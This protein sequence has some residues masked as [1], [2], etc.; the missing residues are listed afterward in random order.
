MVTLSDE[1]HEPGRCPGLS[2][3]NAWH[4]HG[5]DP[6]WQYVDPDGYDISDQMYAYGAVER[7]RWS[8]PDGPDLIEYR[9][10]DRWEEA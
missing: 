10:G 9:R 7:R 2:C 1:R 4:I 3:P 6:V 8:G 5:C